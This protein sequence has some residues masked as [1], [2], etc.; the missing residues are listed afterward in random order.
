MQFFTTVAG[1]DA[2][3]K[4]WLET[5]EQ[6]I[7]ENEAALIT[8]VSAAAEATD[9]AVSCIGNLK[10]E[11]AGARELAAKVEVADYDI[12][13]QLFA[14][15]PPTP[16]ELALLVIRG[17]AAYK[18]A[19]A[20]SPLEKKLGAAE[21]W[22]FLAHGSLVRCPVPRFVGRDPSSGCAPPGFRRHCSVGTGRKFGAEWLACLNAE[23]F[24]KWYVLF[25]L[26]SLC[27]R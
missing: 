4:Q 27:A 19:H 12:F 6:A 23:S 25:L 3:A 5:L 2:T 11:L 15:T 18:A 17:K 9:A 13:C 26:Y 7:R 8:S 24:E 16:D 20:C 22:E 21:Y 14:D 10:S 1:D